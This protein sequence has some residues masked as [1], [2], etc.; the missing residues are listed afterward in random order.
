MANAARR[1]GVELIGLALVG[2]GGAVAAMLWSHHPDDPS[3]FNATGAA[4][5]NLLGAFGASLADP[6]I[7]GLG[8]AASASLVRPVRRL[9]PLGVVKG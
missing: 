1:R 6:M 3:F 4:A 8:L 7:R 2:A 5:H 9:T